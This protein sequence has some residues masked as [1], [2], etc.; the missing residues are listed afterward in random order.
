MT[1]TAAWADLVLPKTT[2]LEEEEI[3]LNQKAP[4]VTY[5]GR[6]ARRDER[7]EVR[8]RHRGRPHQTGLARA[9]RPSQSSCR[10]ARAPNSTNYLVRDSAIDVEALKQ[11]GYA[12][13][14]YA[15]RNFEAQHLRDAEPQDRALFAAH[16]AQRARSAPRLHSARLSARG[17][18]DCRGLSRSCC[19]PDCAR[20]TFHHSRFREQAW[21]K[22][23]SPDPVVY[24]HPET[25]A[26]FGVAGRRLDQGRG[27]WR[28]G[29]VP[30][31]G[32]GDRLTRL[33]DVL[34]TG[35]GWWRPDAPAPHF[36]ARDVNINAALSYRT[37]G[38]RERLGRHARH[39]LAGLCRADA[40]ANDEFG[41]FAPPGWAIEKCRSALFPRAPSSRPV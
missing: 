17:C 30:A 14:P 20:E 34:T 2:T 10:G 22:K 40:N 35:V 8:P 4:C 15:L 36:G 29:L 28:L 13:F 38:P 18:R 32:E 33:P 27:G 5:T 23:V 21:T 31:Q 7:R 41:D 3:N 16:G 39:S 24:M 37:L 26:R 12:E 1:P 9:A 6:L 11:T 19:K 25:A